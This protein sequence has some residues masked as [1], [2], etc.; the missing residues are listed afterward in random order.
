VPPL[1]RDELEVELRRYEADRLLAVGRAEASL[2]AL[3][4]TIGMAIDT[5]V[6]L[7]DRL[8]KLIP[9]TALSDSATASSGEASVTANRA[10][11]RMAEAEVR[12][13]HARIDDATGL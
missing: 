5:P 4:K 9:S 11:V 3:K 13:A 12:L 2:I 1:E 7:R 8:E 10:D 6:Q